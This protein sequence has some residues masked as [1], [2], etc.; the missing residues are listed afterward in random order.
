MAADS[1]GSVSVEI[2]G[3]LSKLSADFASAQA[4]AQKAGTQ[5]AGAFQSGATTIA[6][7]QNAIKQATNNLADA[8][9]QLA[10]FIVAGNKE[11]IAAVEGYRAELAAEQANLI[12]LT[13][14]QAAATAATTAAA[15]AATTAATAATTAGVALGT[16]GAAAGGAVPPVTALAGAAGGAGGALAGLGGAAGGVIPPIAGAGGAA[17]GASIGMFRLYTVITLL[18][19]GLNELDKFRES[20]ELLTHMAEATGVSAE[21]LAQFQGA[22]SLAGG[23]AEQFGQVVNRL[24]RAMET[25]SQGSFKMQDDLHRLGVTAKDP[26]DAFYQIAD[27]VHNTSQ[28]F[29]A[30]GVASQVLGRN[31]VDL[32]GIF[33]GGSAALKA[34]AAASAEVAKAEADAIQSAND[35]TQAQA[36][37]KQAISTVTAESF[38]AI[39]AALKGVAVA[40]EAALLPL[41]I[42]FTAAIDGA[43]LTITSMQSLAEV[44]GDIATGNFKKAAVDAIVGLTTISEASKHLTSDL[45]KDW[46][47]TAAFIA[48]LTASATAPAAGAGTPF[49][50]PGVKPES[51]SKQQSD[52]K[53]GYDEMLDDLKSDHKLT[54]QEELEFWQARLAEVDQFGT[55]YKSLHREIYNTIGRLHQQEDT[56]REKDQDSLNRWAQHLYDVTQKV[57]VANEEMANRFQAAAEKYAASRAKLEA[58]A[59]KKLYEPKPE[60]AQTPITV[61][62]QQRL[63]GA[64]A[65][66]NVAETLKQAGFESSTVL[67]ERIAND[68]RHLQLL[69]QTKAPILEQLALQ[70]QILAE[71][72]DLNAPIQK[73]YELRQQILKAQIDLN[74]A[75]GKTDVT[76]KLASVQLS[77][78]RTLAQW[79]SLDMGDAAKMLENAVTKVPG[80]IGG[81][82]AGA[83]FDRQKGQSVGTEVAT[84][85]K[86]IGKQLFGELLTAAIEKLIAEMALHLLGITLQGSLTAANTAALVTLNATLIEQQATA[87]GA[88]AIGPAASGA[89]SAA[90][91]AGGAVSSAATGLVGPLI[92]AAGG[93]IGGVISGVMSLIGAHQ[94]V[95]A[96][97][98]TTAAVLSLKGQPIATTTTTGLAPGANT[99]AAA[100]PVMGASQGSLMGFFGSILGFGGSGAKPVDVNVVAFSPISPLKGLFNMLG[101]ASG[102]R[103]PVGVASIF[104]ERGP[105]MWIPDEAGTV[106][107]AGKWGG[108]GLSLP[109]SAT[110][111]SSQSIGS[112]H[113]TVNGITN[114]DVFVDHV[115]RKLPDRL[116]ARSP[117]FSPYSR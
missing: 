53:A 39:T 96:I 5:V 50:K 104:G 16:V 66:L 42:F 43:L 56:E 84:A 60:I 79:K 95:K 18:R 103:P 77:M 26:I 117:Q 14:A 71:S 9:K 47:D 67:N 74:A 93:I 54:I 29:E 27:S 62:L 55:K 73:E 68:Q 110:S 44:M 63:G 99:Q 116:K 6:G 21:R 19:R 25:A 37:L 28:R 100:Q 111:T 38:P 33:A 34:N 48:K 105:E 76:D 46:S 85:L 12:Q 89:G 36:Q 58:E 7:A 45:K 10:S 102:G 22:V 64:A 88:S 2:R 98:A 80:A 101:F 87:A 11:A 81:A 17:T 57:A 75:Q 113:F 114:P 24:A 108:A 69:I 1:I 115:M 82:V 8:Q 49:P 61:P 30:L 112:M 23:N 92:A 94:I 13:A 107:P 83:V 65:P 78:Q 40:F 15:A 109:Q 35:L 51:L 32:V 52:I 97:N 3:D 4:A 41:K 90:G 31:A 72:I 86:G 91:A 20:E 59:A 106:I 70:K